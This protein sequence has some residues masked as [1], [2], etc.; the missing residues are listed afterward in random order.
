MVKKIILRV[1]IL[2]IMLTVC[3]IL[4]VYAEEDREA[5]RVAYFSLG[6]DYMQDER[7]GIHS[8]DRSYLDKVSE[9]TNLDF[10][11][12]DCGTWDNALKMLREHQVD[13]VGTMQ[14]TPDREKM[15]SIADRKYGL[16][17]STIATVNN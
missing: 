15:Y 10:E 3:Y 9:Y 16:T 6:D 12:V 8:Y 7:G 11:Y 17:F 13:L 1:Y 2:M 14:N 4:P 5:V